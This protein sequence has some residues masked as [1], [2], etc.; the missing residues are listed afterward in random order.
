MGLELGQEHSSLQP[1][2]PDHRNQA[3][4]LWESCVFS[5]KEGK[6]ATFFIGPPLLYGASPSNL[7]R[8]GD[9]SSPTLL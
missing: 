9:A 5:A 3:K 1:P 4:E 2:Y 7:G 6:F 8:H